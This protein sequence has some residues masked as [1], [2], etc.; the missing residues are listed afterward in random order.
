M[1]LAA[2]IPI[3]LRPLS[4]ELVTTLGRERIPSLRSSKATQNFASHLEASQIGN[5]G[6]HEVQVHLNE[7]ILHAAG[8]RRGEDFLPIQSVLADRHD[9]FGLRGPALDV[10]RNETPRVL[11]EIFRSVKALLNRGDLELKLDQLGVE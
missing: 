2:F 10:H 3:Q 1:E 5:A 4:P 6:L 9:L 11:H 7:I 8:L